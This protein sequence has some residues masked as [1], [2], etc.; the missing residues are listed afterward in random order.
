MNAEQTDRLEEVVRKLSDLAG[1]I[2]SYAVTRDCEELGRMA[3]QLVSLTED[4]GAAL[5]DEEET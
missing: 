3:S 4:A 2:A 1:D 5:T